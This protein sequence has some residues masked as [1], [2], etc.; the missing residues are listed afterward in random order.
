MAAIR[1]SARVVDIPLPEF[2]IPSSL[3]EH[4]IGATRAIIALGAQTKIL[5]TVRNVQLDTWLLFH[6]KSSTCCEGLN[7]H[8]PAKAQRLTQDNTRKRCCTD[9]WL[10]ENEREWMCLDAL[11]RSRPWATNKD[12]PFPYP[13]KEAGQSLAMQRDSSRNATEGGVLV[14]LRQ[15]LLVGGCTLPLPVSACWYRCAALA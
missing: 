15:G 12:T 14:L 6:L 13:F 7:S 11:C 3:Q 2:E 5:E 8:L 10:D 4:E 9:Q 1:E